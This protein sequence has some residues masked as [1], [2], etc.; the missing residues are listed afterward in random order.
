MGLIIC[1]FGV[2]I[3]AGAPRRFPIVDFRFQ[4]AE[5]F[6]LH[7]F[8]SFPLDSRE[9]PGN[10]VPSRC[11][12]WSRALL[13]AVHKWHVSLKSDCGRSNLSTAVDLLRLFPVL[14]IPDHG[15]KRPRYSVDTRNDFT[16]SEVM[17]LPPAEFNLSTQKSKPAKLLSGA[18]FGFLLK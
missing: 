2:R 6:L 16:I 1:W 15:P 3:P 13:F 10:R 7:L 12:N 18:S 14:N 5:G 8:E 17:K 9:E 11:R 4:S